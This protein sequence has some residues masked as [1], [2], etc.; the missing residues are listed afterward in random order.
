MRWG[1]LFASL[2]ATLLV[3]LAVAPAANA[4]SVTGLRCDS[5][6]ANGKTPLL[7]VHGTNTDAGVSWSWGYARVLRNDGHGICT[8]DLPRRALGDV[9]TSLKRVEQAL[10]EVI[11]RARGRKVS[12]I[13][14]SQGAFHAAA[15]LRTAPSLAKRVDDVIGLG[16]GYT[17]GS[18]G[19]AA[20][21]ANGCEPA[22]LQLAAGSNFTR[23]LK[24]L[25]MP[26]GSRITAIGSTADA[27]VTPQ[28]AVN[29]PPSGRGTSIEIQDVCPGRKFFYG[30]DHISLI[31]DAVAF[32]LA[33]DALDHRGVARA[34]RIDR[35]V[36]G[37]VLMPGADFPTFMRSFREFSQAKAPE[38]V[39]TTREPALRCPFKAGCKRPRR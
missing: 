23:A 7:L 20:A 34:G 26:S 38:S 19:V 10:R 28:P 21:C 17:R 37:Q 9:Q 1:A 22:L 24:R 12:L 11:R 2:V 15:V 8:I 36:C 32:A 18:D 29:R 5:G 16:G 3:A 31:G 14:H 27:T 13:G 25:P 30:F 35:G 4:A 33:K 39:V 6:L